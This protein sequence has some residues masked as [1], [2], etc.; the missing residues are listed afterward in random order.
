MK[1]F[2]LGLLFVG[3]GGALMYWSYP[4]MEMFGKNA[5]AERNVGGTRNLIFLIGCFFVIVGG[6]VMFGVVRVTNPAN[7]IP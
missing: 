7:E 3:V 4:I 5:W 1:Q 6:L 2:L